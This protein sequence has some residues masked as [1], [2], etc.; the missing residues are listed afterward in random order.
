MVKGVKIQL[1]AFSVCLTHALSTEEEE[2]MGLLI[3]EVQPPTIQNVINR[4]G[5]VCADH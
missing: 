5:R 1:D 4:R 2:V 3:G